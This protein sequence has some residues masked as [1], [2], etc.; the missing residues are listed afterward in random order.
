[1]VYGGIDVMLWNEHSSLAVFLF[2]M[3][4]DLF[5]NNKGLV[6]LLESFIGSLNRRKVLDL[7]PATF[8]VLIVL[9]QHLHFLQL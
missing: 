3:I 6:I 5:V 8:F 2:S 7:M 4:V 1:M 9:L